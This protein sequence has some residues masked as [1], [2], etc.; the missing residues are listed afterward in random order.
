MTKYQIKYLDSG[1][2]QVKTLIIQEIY[3]YVRF[4]SLQPVPEGL[5]DKEIKEFHKETDA[6]KK[7][8][9]APYGNFFT[10]NSPLYDA[11]KT[12]VL[13]CNGIYNVEI[14]QI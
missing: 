14:K 11:I 10:N 3:E 12:G 13:N 2:T 8:L 7:R 5:S 9:L 1:I 6:M 4:V